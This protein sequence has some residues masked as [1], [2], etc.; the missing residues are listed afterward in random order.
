[1]MTLDLPNTAAATPSD[2]DHA[3]EEFS[4]SPGREAVIRQIVFAQFG[5]Q[6]PGAGSGEHFVTALRALFALPDGPRVVE[7]CHHRDAA[8][9]HEDI[10]MAYWLETDAYRRWRHGPEVSSWWRNLPADGELGYWREVLA[11]DRDRFGLLAF[12]INDKRRFGCTHAAKSKPSENWGYWGGYRDRFAASKT[13]RFEP[14]IGGGPSPGQGHASKGKR[15][16]LTAPNNLCF[17]REGADVSAVTHAQERR[18]WETR[19]KPVFEKFVAYL[20]DNPALSGAICLR[21]T[22]EQDLD[23]GADLPKHNTLIY[24][25]SLRHMER[26]ARTQPSHLA[27]YNTY[28]QMLEDLGAAAISPEMIAWAE[29]HILPRGTT[30]LEYVNCHEQTGLIPYCAVEALT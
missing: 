28:M 10:L 11:P 15:I 9:Y 23:T 5:I 7:R 25:R 27:L 22:I 2:P 21:D 17:V 20:R 12:G 16:R 13:D 6:G 26:A 14:E 18:A 3:H 30:E 8:G 19:V 29:A 4:G 24:F 1:M